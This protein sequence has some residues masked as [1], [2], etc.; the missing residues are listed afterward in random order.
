MTTQEVL[1]ISPQKLSKMSE[2]ELRKAVSILR[3]T[4]RKRYERLIKT[5]TIEFSPSATRLQK[6]G[7]LP[8]VKGMDVITLR[9]EYKRYSQFIKS[10][11]STIKGARENLEKMRQSI[12]KTVGSDEVFEDDKDVVDF[13]KTM[14]DLAD[15]EIGSVLHYKVMGDELEEI[16]D[17][18][19]NASTREILDKTHE[20]LQEIYEKEHFQSEYFK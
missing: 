13:W 11:T 12:R 15:T 4:A 5:E 16:M 10:R 3:S 7:L 9:N 19:P 20:R 1:N 14:D 2:R 18:N 8:S 6:S 17:N